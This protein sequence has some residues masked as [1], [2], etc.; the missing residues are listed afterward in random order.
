MAVF[1]HCKTA[2]HYSLYRED[3]TCLCRVPV[4]PPIDK[5]ANLRL[6]NVWATKRTQLVAL[7]LA[8]G[9]WVFNRPN[10]RSLFSV[11]LFTST[12]LITLVFVSYLTSKFLLFIQNARNRSSPGRSVSSP[13]LWAL[14]RWL[15]AHP[16]LG[17]AL[18]CRL[19]ITLVPEPRA[20][21][22]VV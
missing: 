21:T 20:R 8:R 17:Q 14:F 18:I 5:L 15:R 7:L 10:D 19:R 12:R 1:L 11:E 6:I 22:F 3:L 2:T 9:R 4:V 13:S 16:E